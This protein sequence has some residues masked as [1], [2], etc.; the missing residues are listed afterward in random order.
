[1]HL[2]I[3]ILLSPRMCVSQWNG[4]MR[5][6]SQCVTEDSNHVAVACVPRHLALLLSVLDPGP[7]ISTQ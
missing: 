1:M 6:I 2:Q 3:L 4:A 5:G 7:P